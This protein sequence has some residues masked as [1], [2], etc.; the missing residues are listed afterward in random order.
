MRDGRI[1]MQRSQRK[2]TQPVLTGVS[3]SWE[4]TVNVAATPDNC[5][6]IEIKLIY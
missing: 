4:R 5:W 1:R 3:Y 2:G 6:C